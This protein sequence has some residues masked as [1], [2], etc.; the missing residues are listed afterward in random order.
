MG[1]S[2]GCFGLNGPLRQYFRLYR[3]VS[4]REGER[5]EKWQT[6][7]KMSKLP[8][9]A[10]AASAKRHC[11]TIIQ[12]RRTPRHLKFTHPTTPFHQ[13]GSTSKRKR[14]LPK[15]FGCFST[16]IFEK[17]FLSCKSWA[18][19]SIVLHGAN[20]FISCR[21]SSLYREAK[22]VIS[23]CKNVKKNNGDAPTR[24]KSLLMSIEAINLCLVLITL[25]VLVK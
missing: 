22:E 4:Q 16:K 8:P 25:A 12:F 20:S 19:A 18:A 15:E 1:W 10:P 17:Q 23:P 11:P 2:V 7:E 13:W 6:R 24:L 9:P 14:L 3:A 21:P 5:K